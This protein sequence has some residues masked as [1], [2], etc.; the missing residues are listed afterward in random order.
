VEGLSHAAQ[1][2]EAAVAGEH[3]QIRRGECSTAAGIV[4]CPELST[5][6]IFSRP[7]SAI[8]SIRAPIMATTHE[9]RRQVTDG[10]DSCAG[11]L[12]LLIALYHGELHSDSLTVKFGAQFS[13]N[14]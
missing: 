11:D 8:H 13:L 2:R 1:G 12:I 6:T 7:R 10:D 5:A 3:I 4:Y 14:S 9:S